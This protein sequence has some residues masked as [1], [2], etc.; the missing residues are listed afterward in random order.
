MRGRD[1]GVEWQVQWSCR[2]LSRKRYKQVLM[3]SKKTR[4]VATTE[5]VDC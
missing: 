2:L 5:A 4:K 1:Q 3:L